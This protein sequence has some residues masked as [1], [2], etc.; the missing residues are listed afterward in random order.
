MNR[1]PLLP[2][3]MTT[4][5]VWIGLA[6]FVCFTAAQLPDRV[7]T[8][9]GLGGVPNGWMTRGE[10]VQFTLLMGLV[11]PVFVVGLF[12]FLRRFHGLLNIPHKDY[13][14]APERRQET[15]DFILRQGFRFAAM[16]I[17]FIAVIHWSILMANRH[18]P[19]TLP[20]VHAAWIG[21]GFLAAAAVWV[22]AFF[23]RFLR[24]PA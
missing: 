23:V 12:A 16:F 3:L 21:G 15:M 7:A 14:L 5:I 2:S 22:L 18:N 24:K 9:F 10:H 8:H 13:W 11:I 17:I 1:H 20:G 19:A 4:V 6:S